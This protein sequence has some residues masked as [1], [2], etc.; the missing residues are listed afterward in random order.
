[1]TVAKGISYWH[2]DSLSRK[3]SHLV[4]IAMVFVRS[5]DACR[6]D[7]SHTSPVVLQNPG[8]SILIVVYLPPYTV[9]QL[10]RQ[11]GEQAVK[12]SQGGRAAT[13]GRSEKWTY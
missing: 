2:L 4:N 9:N 6:F 1:M 8:Y 12:G 11:R 5:S 3:R 10:H 13:R 7:L